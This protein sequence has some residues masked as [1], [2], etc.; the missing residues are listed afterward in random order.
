MI[1]QLQLEPREPTSVAFLWFNPNE[2][3]SPSFTR[4]FLGSVSDL[5]V[6]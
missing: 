2:L 6:C 5:L 3:I 4:L 1:S